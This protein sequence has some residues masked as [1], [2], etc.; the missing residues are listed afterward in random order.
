MSCF[1]ILKMLPLSLPTSYPG[2][3]RDRKIVQRVSDVLLKIMW[4]YLIPIHYLGLIL[5]TIKTFPNVS[6]ISDKLSAR[7]KVIGMMVED[8][9]VENYLSLF[10]SYSRSSVVYLLQQSILSHFTTFI[11]AF[12]TLLL[13]GTGIFKHVS[14]YCKSEF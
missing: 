8:N 11:N 4:I 2:C 6:F 14:F 9:L 12:Q 1:I 7:E 3:N 13:F 10:I 5:H